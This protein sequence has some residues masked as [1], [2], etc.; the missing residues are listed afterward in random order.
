MP[1]VGG[2][3]TQA[4]LRLYSYD[5]SDDGGSVYLVSNTYRDSS[6]PWTETG[7]NWNNAPLLSAS[8]LAAVGSVSTGV[9]VDFDVTAAVTGSGTYSFGLSNTSS[10][11]ALYYSKE[12]A[13]NPPT[14]ILNVQTGETQT[15][16][17]TGLT[18]TVPALD[19]S[20]LFEVES[21]NPIIEQSGVWT[22][23]ATGVASG[24]RY[25]YSSGSSS[26][27]LT[28]HFQGTQVQ[29]VYVEHPALGDFAIEVDGVPMQV[30][31][32]TASNAVFG[33]RA[34][35]SGLSQ[36]NHTVRLVPVNGTMAIDA[37]AVEALAQ[38]SSPMPT[39]AVNPEPSFTPTATAISAPPELTASP[40]ATPVPVLLPWS[41][42]FETNTMNW[43]ASGAWL[44]APQ[45]GYQGSGWFADG[46]VGGQSSRL[47]SE[48]AVDLRMAQHPELSFWQSADLAP[49]DVIAVDILLDGTTW[50]TIDQQAGAVWAWTQ[51][52]LDLTPYRN[53][54]INLRFRLE[55]S[56][57]RPE[58]GDI[59]GF[60][61]DELVI[62]DRPV[63][64]ATPLPTVA[65]LPTN[66]EIPLPAETPT[67]VPTETETSR[68]TETPTQLPTETLPAS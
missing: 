27:T 55:A 29:I 64:T 63:P 4:T 36:G 57:S 7:L 20:A 17:A 62:Y 13:V 33:V 46:R 11:S 1:D 65:P 66:T 38:V 25:L 14:L 54:V 58:T 31:D 40:T 60:W 24:G 16:F 32:S 56:L 47:T 53:S 22:A 49:D 21:D 8:P 52:T 26:D 34:S 43:T 9:F 5:G 59:L 18:P 12:S 28:M 67:P 61:L 35:I 41:E 51:R 3:I 15:I 10:N 50:L 37:F 19:S 6:T 2:V 42:T 44:F 23:Y 68:P 48:V 39:A 30:V 45:A